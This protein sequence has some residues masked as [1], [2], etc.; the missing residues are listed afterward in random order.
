VSFITIMGKM[1]QQERNRLYTNC[2]VVGPSL[3]CY[4][5]EELWNE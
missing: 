3:L 5:W 2:K 1:S 4:A